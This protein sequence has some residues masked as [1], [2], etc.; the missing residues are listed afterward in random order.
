MHLLSENFRLFTFLGFWMPQEYKSSK[1]KSLAY[2]AYSLTL[3]TLLL[4]LISM[5]IANISQSF[6]AIR[7]VEDCAILLLGVPELTCSVFKS[8]VIHKK[9]KEIFAIERTFLKCRN[10]RDE[11]EEVIQNQ[12]DKICRLV[13]AN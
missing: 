2:N 3:L 7:N 5:K 13:R 8:V 6:G 1:L 9:R 4:T 10:R 12:C 11:G